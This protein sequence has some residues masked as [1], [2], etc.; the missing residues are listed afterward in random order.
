MNARMDADCKKYAIDLSAYFD[1]ELHGNALAK[2]ESHLESCAACQGEL[3]THS[4]IRKALIYF[5]TVA[6]KGKPPEKSSPAQDGG[7][8]EPS[9][10]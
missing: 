5:A 8:D 2:L 10:N 7:E 9:Q 6:Q 3:E 4:K 1:R